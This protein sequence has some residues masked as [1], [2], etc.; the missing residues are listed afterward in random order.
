MKTIGIVGGL[1][2]PS[3]AIYYRTINELVAGRL[4]G[5]HCARLVLAQTD[6]DQVQRYQHQGRWD[7]VGDLLAAQA[8]NLKAAGADFFL[9]A[10]NTVHTA[11]DRIEEQA[12][13]P[14][15]HIVDPTARQIQQAGFTT[16]G[17][18]GSRYTMTGTYFTARLQRR[19]GLNVLVA[20]G[21][22]Q[23]NVHHA[24]YTELARGAIL[25]ATRAKFQA[26]ITDLVA[27]GAQVI[28]LACT[29]FGMVVQAEDSP[30]PVIDTTVAHAQAAVEMAL[31]DEPLQPGT[32]RAP[33][34]H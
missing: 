11:A 4:G 27:R 1:A 25:P 29:E 14:F 20:E 12:G 33:G 28:V 21:E 16:V 31:A 9:L 8:R 19:Y 26:A 10:C 15:L 34:T 17:L 3:S 24:L 7:L 23:D 2:W 18:L 30:V 22:H 32:Y 6:F 5:L 13:L